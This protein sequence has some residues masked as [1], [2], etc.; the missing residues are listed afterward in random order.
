VEDPK[1][2]FMGYYQNLA[3]KPPNFVPTTDSVEAAN[4]EATAD[5]DLEVVKTKVLLR[6]RRIEAE[7]TSSASGDSQSLIDET[8]LS[9]DGT[10]AWGKGGYFR[11][12]RRRAY[13]RLTNTFLWKDN[14]SVVEKSPYKVGQPVPLVLTLT[15]TNGKEWTFEN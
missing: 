4:S 5:T 6:D 2:P 11:R 3:P 12:E 8:G 15:C 7:E 9:V 13:S 14:P 10:P 1:A